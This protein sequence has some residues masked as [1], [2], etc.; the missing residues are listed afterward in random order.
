MHW[1]NCVLLATVL[2]LTSIKMF[3]LN[4]QDFYKKLFVTSCLTWLEG[5]GFCGKKKNIFSLSWE[6]LEGF[7][8]NFFFT[9]LKLEK[10]IFWAELGN[11]NEIKNSMAEG[12]YQILST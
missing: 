1:L 12:K 9:K 3:V 5:R 2:V 7:L 11:S 6:S 4:L 10:V 8:V